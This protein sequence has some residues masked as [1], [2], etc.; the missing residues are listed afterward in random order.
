MAL[1]LV[2]ADTIE[3]SG[4][5]ALN[6]L[7]LLAPNLQLLSFNPRN[8]SANTRRLGLNVALASDGFEQGVAVYIDNVYCG[9]IG[10][11]QFDLMDLQQAEVRRGLQR[12]LFGK[13]TTAGTIKITS[14]KPSFE[15]GAT[16]EVSIGEDEYHQVRDT[17]MGTVAEGIVAYRLTSR[18][19][20]CIMA[21]RGAGQ[22]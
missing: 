1:S 18:R 6:Q 13:N 2:S 14:Q 10:Q 4:V 11:A 19:R 9:P 8:T 5:L 12:T 7:Q 16:G 22:V 17:V 15:F 20:D 21:G 3:R